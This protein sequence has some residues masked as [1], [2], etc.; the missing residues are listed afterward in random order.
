MNS[1]AKYDF[2]KVSSMFLLCGEYYSCEPYGEG[3]INETF[4]LIT[5][6]GE[7]EHKYI[8]QRVNSTLFTNVDKLMN[9]IALVTEFS[10]KK[11]TERGGNPDRESLT[12]VKTVDGNNY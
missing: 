3:H 5:K 9:N 1:G 7:T 2:K 6:Q 4:L 12:I 10:R 8:L 11:I